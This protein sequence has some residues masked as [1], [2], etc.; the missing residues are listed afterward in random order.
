MPLLKNGSII[1]DDW[2]TLGLDD[3]KPDSGDIVV[4]YARLL[5][6]WESLT[7]HDGRLGVIFTNIDRVEALT[8]FLPRLALIV[9]PFPSFT[10]GRAYSL[11]RQIRE[12]G[13]GRELRAAGNVLPDQ[14]QFML[15]VGF[16]SFEIGDRFTAEV[17]LKASRQM[18]LAYQRGLYRTP[19]QHD[20]WSERHREAEPWLEQPH[21]G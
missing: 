11:A 21:A 1:I 20:V 6:E 8:L 17:W 9:L 13:Y 14:V 15:Q 7:D 3:P 19:G 5:K 18:S 2:I 4:P 10:D 16:D 12:T